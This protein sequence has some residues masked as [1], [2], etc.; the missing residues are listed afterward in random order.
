[1]ANVIEQKN[2]FILGLCSDTGWELAHRYSEN[3]FTVV[4]T[5][6]NPKKMKEF[7]DTNNVS[8]IPCDIS[9]DNSIISIIPNFSNLR[10]PWNIFIFCIGAMTPIGKFASSINRI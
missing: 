7:C 2:V 4:G 9:D 8:S 1:M 6:R 5:C 3:G 10:I